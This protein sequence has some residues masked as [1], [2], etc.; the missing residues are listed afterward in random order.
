MLNYQRVSGWFMMF[1]R[2]LAMCNKKTCCR[3]GR[4]RFFEKDDHATRN[5]SFDEMSNRG[6]QAQIFVTLQATQFYIILMGKVTSHRIL[7]VTQ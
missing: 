6:E 5:K 7:G 1:S 3:K 2:E 4:G